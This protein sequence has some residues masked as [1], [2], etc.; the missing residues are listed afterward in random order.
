MVY[1]LEILSTLVGLR[2]LLTK[3]GQNFQNFVFFLFSQRTHSSLICRKKIE[4]LKKNA[5]YN[6]KSVLVE[7]VMN[8]ERCR[9]PVIQIRPPAE[10]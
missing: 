2:L 9:N 8:S 3:S 10:C 4:N 7:L 6:E 5:R 1:V